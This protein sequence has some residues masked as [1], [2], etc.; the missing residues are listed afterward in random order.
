[1]MTLGLLAVVTAMNIQINVW[2][3]PTPLV[4]ASDAQAAAGVVGA[5][6]YMSPRRAAGVG[7]PT[8][9]LTLAQVDL[10]I[11]T[12]VPTMIQ[13]NADFHKLYV[14]STVFPNTIG[15]RGLVQ[16]P[17][18]CLYDY[19]NNASIGAMASA[20]NGDTVI[21]LTD[22]TAPVIPFQQPNVTLD[23]NSHQVM[24]TNVTASILFWPSAPRSDFLFPFIFLNDNCTVKNGTLLSD[25]GLP[26]SPGGLTTI[27]FGMQITFSKLSGI[28]AG[29][30]L[31]QILEVSSLNNNIG[32]TNIGRWASFGITNNG[33]TN[34]TM[35]KVYFNQRSY[36]ITFWDNAQVE[37]TDTN[38]NGDFLV[39]NLFRPVQI[40]FTDCSA[41]SYWDAWTLRGAN[42]NITFNNQLTTI[43]LNSFGGNSTP[44][45]CGGEGSIIKI[46]GGEYNCYAY[47]N[48]ENLKPGLGGARAPSINGNNICY[49]SFAGLK[50]TS[51]GP[52]FQPTLN[53][54]SGASAVSGWYIDTNG[55][56][57]TFPSFNISYSGGLPVAV[58]LITNPF[59]L[60]NMTTI[61]LECY[62]SGSVAY[63]I[64]KNGSAVYGSLAGDNYF[65]L[66]PTNQ[67]TIT[68]TVAPS[69]K[70]N[71]LP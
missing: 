4:E 62:F 68:Y 6:F 27:D 16:A 23:L 54:S 14:S 36:D 60:T 44:C 10:Q 31:D 58:T 63:S 65:I 67:C 64:T 20:T 71:S 22:V 59:T 49:I 66:Q 51:I 12:N 35:Q 33:G 52:S 41:F 29:T 2:A 7:G 5:P 9:G 1:M 57:Q 13:T 32:P 40:T 37:V 19:T 38:G 24:R 39:N 30:N 46:I 17:W 21:L 26:Y 15:V 8:N 61:P 48:T 56:A 45:W 47:T 25:T 69:F 18:G 3:Q 43:G 53:I 50:L 55:I 42:V 28:T 70:T 34:V 11:A